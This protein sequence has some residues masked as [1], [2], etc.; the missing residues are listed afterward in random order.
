MASRKVLFEIFFIYLFFIKFCYNSECLSHSFHELKYV[1]ALTL[2]NGYHLM[3]TRTGIFTFY[4]SLANFANSYNFT[5][6][7]ILEDT[8]ASMVG[9]MNQVEISQFIDEEG[10]EKYVICLANNYIYFMDE[11]GALITYFTISDLDASYSISLV[12]YLYSNGNYYFVIAYNTETDKSLILRYYKI[13][14]ENYIYKMALDKSNKFYPSNEGTI[15]PIN[16][17]GISCQAMNSSTYGKVLTCIVDIQN[18]KRLAAYTFKPQ[19]NNFVLLF[20]NDFHYINNY[21][22][23]N[24][25]YIKSALNNDK[26]KALIC[27]S[28]ESPALKCLSYD[29]NTKAFNDPQL[30]NTDCKVEYYGNNVN[31]FEKTNEF[32]LSWVSSNNDKFNFLRLRSDYGINNN[33]DDLSFNQNTFLYCTYYDLSS[34]IYVSKY[35]KYLT[36]LSST[37]GGLNNVRVF[38]LTNGDCITLTPD[39]EELYQETTVLTIITTMPIIETTIPIIETSI[40]TTMPIIE[41]T[42]PIIETTIITT[43]PIIESTIPIIE[44]TILDISTTMPIIETTIPILETTILDIITT[45]PIIETT[46]PILETTILDIITTIPIIEITIPETT[47]IKIITTFPETNIVDTTIMNKLPETSIFIPITTSPDIISTITNNSPLFSTI[48]EE[49]KE[50]NIYTEKLCEEKKI[51][52]EGKCICDKNKGYYSI[53]HNEYNNECY[54]LEDL[55]QNIY[56]NENIQS[57]E[58][59]Y[60][61]CGTCI[62]GGDFYENNCLTC[63][64]DYIKEKEDDDA[65]NCVEKCNY[66]YYYNIFNQYTCT[67]DEQCPEEASFIV[68][69]KDKCTSKCINEDINI[70]QYNGECLSF[71]PDNTF[72]NNYY[73]CQIKNTA[74]CSTGQFNLNL[75]ENIDQENVKLV[76][77]NYATEFHYTQNHISTFISKN[78]TMALYKNSSCIDELELNI[79]KIEYDSCIQQLKKDNNIDENKDLIIA[80]IDIVNDNNPV[81][82]FGFFHPETGEKLDANKSCSD[83]NIIMYENLLS[84]LNDPL[85][86]K[87]LEDQKINIFDLNDAFYHDICFHFKSPNGKDATLQDRM[88]SFYPNVTL[89]DAGCKNKGLNFTTMKAECECKFQDLLSKNIYENDLF[90]NNILMKESLEEISEMLSNLNIEILMCFKDVFDYEYFKKN[91]SGFIIMAIFILY[92]IFIFYYYMKSKNQTLRNIYILT[93]KYILYLAQTNN[94]PLPKN[95]KKEYKITYCPIKKNKINFYNK[96]NKSIN[97][98]AKDIKNNRTKVKFKDNNKDKKD[99]VKILKLKNENKKKKNRNISCKQLNIVNFNFKPIRHLQKRNKNKGYSIKSNNGTYE[100]TKNLTTKIQLLNNKKNEKEKRKGE[101]IINHIN[102]IFILL[103]M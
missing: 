44:T 61:S 12:S 29:I 33:N 71:C 68:R 74:I 51:Y 5:N 34:I 49:N 94:S 2:K 56:F 87:L 82:S 8:L 39:E 41:T 18:V 95:N 98:Q 88:K 63:S 58:F 101:I 92:T 13:Y 7:Q 27:Y 86:L 55:P 48:F 59:C 97:I 52:S 79:T 22:N 35:N 57:Y 14:K 20:M 96:S 42:I 99:E 10:G 83:K 54:K 93:E 60:K 15:F 100:S 47:I 3:V 85:A 53:K 73:I 62:K 78:F 19:N 91:K 46:I 80:V 69:I 36:I 1:K 84:L 9:T 6:E 23:K 70:Y 90:G 24:A 66:L 31:Y 77:K 103:K 81:T 30:S 72:V 38:T 64:K 17:T 102:L 16:P 65:S 11:K 40:I 32:V 4:P 67:E 45:I 50:A 25:I 76:A 37:C 28:V 43:I 75:E 21:D 26:S 89:C